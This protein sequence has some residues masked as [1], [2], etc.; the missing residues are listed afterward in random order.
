MTSDSTIE[1]Q[2]V[3]P[4]AAGCFW[5]DAAV[6]ALFILLCLELGAILCVYPWMALWSR[7]WFL[8]VRPEWQSFL[9]SDHFRGALT[10][11]G[12]LNLFIA[13]AEAGRLVRSILR[14]LR[15]R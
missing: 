4:P 6:S 3:P 15:R 13:I 7:N 11:L 12:L 10:G 9:L 8:Q 1:A 5:R 2:P 14:R